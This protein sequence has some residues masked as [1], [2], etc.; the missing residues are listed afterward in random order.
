MKREHYGLDVI[1]FSKHM[2][3]IFLEGELWRSGKAIALRPMRSSVQVLKTAYCGN[4]GKDSIHKTQS[5]RTLRNR[6]LRALG[7][8]FE[9]EPW[10]NGKVVAFSPCGHGFM[11]WKQPLAEMQGNV[12]YIRYKVVRRFLGHWASGSYIFMICIFLLLD[13]D[14]P[15]YEHC[16]MP[17][18]Y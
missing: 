5:G 10:R 17:H 16:V 12:S 14:N 2:I 15:N 11:S 18:R 1:R 4:T 7:C 13:S 8:P 3:C 9:G 6:E